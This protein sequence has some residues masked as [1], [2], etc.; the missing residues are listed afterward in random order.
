MRYL[1]PGI[2]SCGSLCALPSQRKQ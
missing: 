2:P 1:L